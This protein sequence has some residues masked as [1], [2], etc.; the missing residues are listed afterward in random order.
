MI[1]N[2]CPQSLGLETCFF[3]PRMKVEILSRL[4]SVPRTTFCVQQPRTAESIVLWTFVPLAHLCTTEISA[5]GAGC[6]Q[7]ETQVPHPIPKTARGRKSLGN[8]LGSSNFLY[9]TTA[10]NKPFVCLS[11]LGTR[12]YLTTT[13]FPQSAI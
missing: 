11:Q 12:N 3:P 7:R 4:N 1:S 9:K 2:R 6:L 10:K 8:S 13:R 5:H